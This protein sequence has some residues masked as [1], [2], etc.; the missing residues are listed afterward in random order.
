M[1]E[2]IRDIYSGNYAV[3]IGAIFR[4][5][6]NQHDKRHACDSIECVFGVERWTQRVIFVQNMCSACIGNLRIIA[7]LG[8]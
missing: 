8:V 3:V 7:V 6:F 1:H 2:A 4:Y 5:H